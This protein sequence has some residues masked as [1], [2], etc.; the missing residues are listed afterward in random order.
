M[1]EVTFAKGSFQIVRFV[2]FSEIF[3]SDHPIL[4]TP[5]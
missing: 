4:P 1:G 5:Q 3:L 2:G